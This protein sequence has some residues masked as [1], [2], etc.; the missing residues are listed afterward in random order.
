MPNLIELEIYQ[1]YGDMSPHKKVSVN[2]EFIAFIE[3]DGNHAFVHMSNKSVLH[4]VES[5]E[6]ILKHL[7]GVATYVT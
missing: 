5:R 2:A 6:Y 7:H 4:T 3:D 1:G